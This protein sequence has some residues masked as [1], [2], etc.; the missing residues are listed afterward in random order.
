MLLF[1]PLALKRGTLRPYAFWLR[2]RRPPPYG[3]SEITLPISNPKFLD[4]QIG[5]SSHTASKTSWPSVTQEQTSRY[6]R[7]Q[8]KSSS[9]SFFPVQQSLVLPT[10]PPPTIAPRYNPRHLQ[11]PESWDAAHSSGG[12]PRSIPGRTELPYAIPQPYTNPQVQAPP[13]YQA[14]DIRTYIP[15]CRRCSRRK[16]AIRSLSSI[17]SPTQSRPAT[18]RGRHPW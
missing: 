2:L 6:G 7:H 4:S 13:I 5:P 3:D 18:Q 11:L 14:M 8:V 15:Q 16:W 10:P 1:L 12:R 9:S 17:R